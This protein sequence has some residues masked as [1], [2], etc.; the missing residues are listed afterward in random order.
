MM[1]WG[2]NA[3]KIANAT[4]TVAL[5]PGQLSSLYGYRNEIG[6]ERRAIAI[7]AVPSLIG[8][9]LGGW[10]MLHT[11]STVFAKIVPYLILTATTLFLIQEPVQKWQKR[12]SEAAGE[13]G[14]IKPVS[15]AFVMLFQFGVAIYGGYFGGGAGMIILASLGLMGLTNIHQM[16]GLKNFFALT[17]NV[18]AIFAFMANGL[19]DWPIAATMGVG[20]VLGGFVGSRVAQ[21]VPQSWVRGAVGVIGAG[22]AAWLFLHLH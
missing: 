18:V 5:W 15:P 11:R 3:A 14:V 16:N 20:S 13:S 6:T 12:R 1:G 8:G 7:M 10:L 4:S 17:F 21:R 9:I 19:I 22:A 2:V